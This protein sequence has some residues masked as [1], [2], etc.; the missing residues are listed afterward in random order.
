MILVPLDSSSVVTWLECAF[1][2]SVRLPVLIWLP[3]SAQASFSWPTPHSHLPF[4]QQPFLVGEGWHL[5]WCNSRSSCVVVSVDCPLWR[6]VCLLCMHTCVPLQ[7]GCWHL[8]QLL[9]TSFEMKSFCQADWL[10]CSPLDLPCAF[11]VLGLQEHEATPCFFLCVME[12]W[13]RFLRF[14]WLSAFPTESCPRPFL[15]H[16]QFVLSCIL[17]VEPLSSCYWWEL[18]LQVGYWPHV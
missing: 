11:P 17:K 16:F 15:V 6:S 7:A 5:L 18:L 1:L 12:S 9:S 8:P 14:M 3:P 2:R 13:T 10:S 4:L